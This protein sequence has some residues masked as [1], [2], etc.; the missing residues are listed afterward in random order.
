MKL[1]QVFDSIEVGKTDLE[2]LK[3]GFSFLD[4]EL[5]GGFLRKELVVLGGFTG[6][7]KSFLA[8]QI[9]FNIAI[10]GFKTSYFSLEISNQM[11]ISRLIGQQAN[12]KPIRILTDWLKEE[13]QKEKIEAKAKLFSSDACLNFYDDIYEL[14]QIS[15][16]I[17]QDEV[18][19][20]VVDF[21]QNVFIKN[22]P[23]EY[24][25][26]TFVSLELQKLA[27]ETNSTVLLLS[28]LSNTAAKAGAN[29][30]IVEYKG[31]GGIAQVADLGFWITR[32]EINKVQLNLRKN[33]RGVSGLTFQFNIKSPGGLF[34]Q[35]K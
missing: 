34:E 21:V 30:G 27:K 15:K 8:G 18:E 14:S 32:S 16:Q 35:T 10:Q 20:A 9:L 24:S 13:E 26:L 5:D 28:Q 7:G 23:D 11:L 25:R 33:R 2:F 22:M 17:K 1:Q 29:S 19:F 6:S 4:S 31:S 12:I 3:T